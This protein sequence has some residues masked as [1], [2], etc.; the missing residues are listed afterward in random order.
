M[1]VPG[2]EALAAL[3]TWRGRES[4]VENS[5]GH[6]PHAPEFAATGRDTPGVRLGRE[7]ERI[8]GE[9]IST[10][11]PRGSGETKREGDNRNMG[12]T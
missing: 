4:R 2:R 12:E 5:R 7:R 8:T 6:M 9:D 1:T 3:R 10:E 11:S